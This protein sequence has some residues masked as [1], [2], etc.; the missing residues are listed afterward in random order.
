LKELARI[1]LEGFASSAILHSWVVCKSS[2]RQ[3]VCGPDP[4]NKAP[5]HQRLQ[6][7]P[8]RQ[9]FIDSCAF[10]DLSPPQG[11]SSERVLDR[12]MLGA[13]TSAESSRTHIHL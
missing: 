13:G 1:D 2:R 5:I 3:R 10:G 8:A 12:G 4:H 6:V 11:V 9:V 7:V